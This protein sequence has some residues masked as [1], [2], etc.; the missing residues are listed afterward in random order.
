M[1][2]L[3]LTMQSKE[4]ANICDLHVNNE[5]E[6]KDH[7][8]IPDVIC[9]SIGKVYTESNKKK[10][11]FVK[12]KENNNTD[13]FDACLASGLLAERHTTIMNE[14]N[15]L[16]TAI[17]YGVPYD[18]TES[19]KHRATEIDTI[20]GDAYPLNGHYRCEMELLFTAGEQYTRRVVV[21]FNSVN[22]SFFEMLQS[23]Y[24]DLENIYDDEEP[25]FEDLEYLLKNVKYDDEIV[26]Q[27]IMFDNFGSPT[28]IEL[29]SKSEFL[30]M[31][32]SARMLSVNFER[33]EKTTSVQSIM[34]S[35]L[36]TRG[37]Q[38]TDEKL[39]DL[40]DI[41]ED[42]QEWSEDG[43]KMLTGT[44]F[45]EIDEFV[46]HNRHVDEIFQD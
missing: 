1:K 37:Y 22:I 16:E 14:K 46:R 32:V 13:I 3:H 15:E 45:D 6:I 41:Y 12:D 5:V 27:I 30:A 39:S 29:N 10:S 35:C 20:V 21:A 25:E 38:V 19:S 36:E 9:Q 42:C 17:L 18:I 31:L 23:I 33:K 11:F 44:S 2:T 28:E 8:P 43:T 26:K 4:L 7:E 24:E 40:I 34:R